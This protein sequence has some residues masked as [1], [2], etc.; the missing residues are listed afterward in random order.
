MGPIDQLPL[1]P[2][3]FHILLAL[4]EGSSHGYAIGKEVERRSHGQINPT[5]G[6]LYQA[7][8]RLTEAGLVERD[9]PASHAS[10]D[11][12]RQYFRLTSDGRR[13]AG[14]EAAR[15]EELVGLAKERKLFPESP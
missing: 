2:L 11:A 12:R 9:E 10:P 13:A 14:L 3:S 5:T 6:A 15:L 8:R 4:A 1:S 7:L